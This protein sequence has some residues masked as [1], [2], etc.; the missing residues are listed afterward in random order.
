MSE[1]T[2]KEVDALIKNYFTFINPEFVCLVVDENDEVIAF[3]VSMPSLSRAFQKAKGR[4]F[5]FGIFYIM[6]ALK[7]TELIDLLLIGVH[8][9]WQ[10]K[11]IHSLIYV[12]MNKDYIRNKCR[13]AIAS[14][15]LED[16]KNAVGIWDNYNGKPYIRRRCYVKLI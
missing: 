4:I 8:P 7:K 3:G 6:S 1:L 5:P 12:E 11:G 16:N 14:P 2:E 15:Q 10:K 13:I 9:D